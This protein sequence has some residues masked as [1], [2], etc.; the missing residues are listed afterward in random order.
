MSFQHIYYYKTLKRDSFSIFNFLVRDPRESLPIN[1]TMNEIKSCLFLKYVLKKI[2][3]WTTYGVFNDDVGT[4][5]THVWFIR[6]TVKVVVT[7]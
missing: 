2:L 5:A 4:V 6:T 1:C 7:T 3:N